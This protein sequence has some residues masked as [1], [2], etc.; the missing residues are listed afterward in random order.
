M[1][2]DLLLLDDSLD[3]Y[4]IIREDDKKVARAI[5]YDSGIL[6]FLLNRED[7]AL[8]SLLEL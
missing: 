2:L 5:R 8:L 3:L 7:S 4:K 1:L 6:R